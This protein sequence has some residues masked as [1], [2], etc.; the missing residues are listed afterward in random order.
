[1]YGSTKPQMLIIGPAVLYCKLPQPAT[2]A[3]V[4]LVM[5]SGGAIR[6]TAL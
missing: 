1:M 5:T 6:L 3:A 4:E 2:A